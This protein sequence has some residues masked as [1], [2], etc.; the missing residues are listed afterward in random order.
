VATIAERSA[1]TNRTTRSPD[2]TPTGGT[3]YF[4][5]TEGSVDLIDPENLTAF[6]VECPADLPPAALAATARRTGLG[7]VLP[8]DDHVLIEVD[9]VRRLAAGRVGP[10]WETEFTGMLAYAARKGWVDESGTKVRAHVERK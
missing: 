2:F 9:A 5:I 8:G 10:A 3:L 1:R 7:E 6:H 4:R